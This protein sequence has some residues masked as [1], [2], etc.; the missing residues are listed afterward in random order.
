MLATSATPAIT[1]E[2]RRIILTGGTLDLAIDRAD[3]P[4]DDLC[5][6]AERENPK[7]GFLI[8]S[9]ILGRHL[10]TRPSA[11]RASARALASRIDPAL[12]GPVLVM[13][14]AE[15]AIC[16]GQSVFEEILRARDDVA[17]VPSTRMVI[18]AEVLT[19]FEEPHSHASAHLVYR[20]E[21]VALDAV[22]SLIIVDDEISTGRTILNLVAAMTPHL[23]KLERTL[24]AALTDWSG[25]AVEAVGLLS[26]SLRW[27][28]DPAAPFP[29]PAA[30][31]AAAPALGALDQRRDFGR[32]GG[33]GDLIDY[34]AMAVRL[35]LPSGSRVRVLG[36][37]EFTYAP[38]RLGEALEA[39]GHDVVMQSTTRSPAKLGAAM[40]RMLRFSDNYG[41][42]VP[43]FLYNAD[44]GD[45][46][47]TIV[48][49]ETPVGS[50]APVLIDAFGALT[51]DMAAS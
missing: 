35:D 24:A 37:G 11:M 10:P 17:F 40:A 28:R 34:V 23:P 13:G 42:D 14:L 16:L 15:T 30:F 32:L 48:A 51:F 4:L 9:K 8:V 6:F 33:R 19:R 5:A 38:F 20:P 22:R 3:W 49:H 27:T 7:R 43:N 31:S 45:V 39:M 29:Q 1:P 47:L 44:P 26:G 21:R 41:T 2:R 12:P 36:T 18:D 25:G 50:I 46:R